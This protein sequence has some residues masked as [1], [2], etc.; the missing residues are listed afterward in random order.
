[1]TN[2]PNVDCLVHVLS[3]WVI[4]DK[5]QIVSLAEHVQDKS[6]AQTITEAA[7]VP[8]HIL[9][10]YTANIREP[11]FYHIAE[12]SLR[13]RGAFSVWTKCKQLTDTALSQMQFH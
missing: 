3:R 13:G 11:I 6:H 2:R 1:M 5:E 10:A 4:T 7:L 8:T 9:I 12:Q